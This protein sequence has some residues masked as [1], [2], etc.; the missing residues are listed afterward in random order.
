MP[1]Q[2]AR[3]LADLVHRAGYAAVSIAVG[4]Q[5]LQAR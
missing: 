4:R 5:T 1:V 3:G 2:M